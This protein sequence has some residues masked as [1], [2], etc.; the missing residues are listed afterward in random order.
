MFKTF[1]KYSGLTIG[2]IAIWLWHIWMNAGVYFQGYYGQGFEPF[3]Q[4]QIMGI[5]FLIDHW[6]K[7]TVVYAVTHIITQLVTREK[8]T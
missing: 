4:S 8:N 3:M 6:L 1:K 5:P 2:Y 7:W